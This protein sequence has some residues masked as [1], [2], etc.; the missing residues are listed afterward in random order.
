M[1]IKEHIERQ[2]P[3]FIRTDHPQFVAFLEA[4]YE[5]LETNDYTPSK[6]QSWSDIDQTL[7]QF[8]S[9]LYQTFLHNF[10]SNLVADKDLILKHAQEFYRTKGT[11]KS[12][13]FLM[14]ILYD[15]DV[16]FY[17]PKK[18]ILRVSDGKWFIQ[19]TLIVNNITVDSVPV[20]SLPTSFVSTRITGQT[21][22]ASASVDRTNTFYSG[23]ILNELVLSNIVGTFEQGE[24]VSTTAADG[25]V[26]E[27]EIML[28]EIVSVVVDSPG[29]GYKLG[30]PAILVS[31]NGSGGNVVVSEVTTGN[32]ATLSVVKGGSGYQNGNFVLFVAPQ[33]SG[34]N[35]YINV[36]TSGAIHPNTYNIYYETI[37]LEAN[38]PIGNSV[39]SN[40]SATANAANISFANLLHNWKYSNTGPAN[41]V[42]VVNPGAD[43]TQQPSMSVLAN[44]TIQQLGILGRLN[45]ANAGTNYAVNDVIQI[46][47]NYGSYGVGAQAKVSNV[48]ANGAITSVAWVEQTGFP[49]GGAGYQQLNLPSANVV[50]ANGR[51]AIIQVVETLGYG[52][53]FEIINSGL[54]RITR[55]T[56]I[57][58][59]S[60]YDSNTVIDLTAS[61]DGLASAHA[62]TYSGI[63]IYPGRWLNDDGH[64][65]SYNFIEDRDYYQNFSYVLRINE[66]LKEF[67][68]YLNNMTH[69]SGMKI[70]SE[71]LM[72]TTVETLTSNTAN[73]SVGFTQNNANVL[74]VTNVSGNTM[75]IY[76]N[77]SPNVL[78]YKYQGN[79]VTQTI[80]NPSMNIINSGRGYTANTYLL[81][82]TGAFLQASLNANGSIIGFSSNGIGLDNVPQYLGVHWSNGTMLVGKSNTANVQ[83]LKASGNITINS[84]NTS[85]AT[86]T[87]NDNY[88]TPNLGNITVHVSLPS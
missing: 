31:S 51:N 26:L 53:T 85:T 83:L 21:S 9:S 37:G 19:T 61:G 65:S 34:A 33:G 66:S 73:Y 48:D 45:I 11:E 80:H 7:E 1:K 14:R 6:I 10:P 16:K 86:I 67:S 59:G 74:N 71:Y 17:Y 36:S 20:D 35:A 56:V 25:T 76:S 30:D 18:D 5:F 46:I 50:S 81:S 28:S 79:L 43:Y 13:E 87:I 60:N 44:S 8:K 64:I 49:V 12:V 77:T 32:V 27:A 23:A 52:G 84:P 75:Y 69:P 57:N 2:F 82:N 72:D 78:L 42:I 54:G 15:K 3:F 70:F 22:L 55:L 47:N 68:K 29:S 63:K 41:S 58:G 40:I 24:T 38:T 88:N 62:I 4:Y 39:Y